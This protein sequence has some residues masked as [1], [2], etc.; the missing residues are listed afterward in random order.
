MTQRLAQLTR[1]YR[2]A[3]NE[4]GRLVRER[5]GISL[6]ELAAT[7]GTNMGELSRWERGIARPRAPVALRWPEAIEVIS[8]ELDQVKAHTPSRPARASSRESAP[9]APTVVAR[10]PER[11]SHGAHKRSLINPDQDARPRGP[12]GKNNT[13]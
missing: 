2:L 9:P 4:Q 5:S 8:A 12:H 1:A 10:R 11:E 3:E 6:R 7:I 13:R